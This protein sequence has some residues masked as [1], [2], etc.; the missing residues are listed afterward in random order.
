M[1]KSNFYK[2]SNNLWVRTVLTYENFEP[3][4]LPLY[5]YHLS[6]EDESV[7]LLH[8]YFLYHAKT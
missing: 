8:K 1:S 3:M 7:D 4:P 6:S 2:R 5:L